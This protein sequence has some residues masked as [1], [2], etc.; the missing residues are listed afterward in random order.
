LKRKINK[1]VFL[2][3]IISLFSTN[4][5]YPADTERLISSCDNNK[6]SDCRKLAVAYIKQDDLLDSVDNIETILHLYHKACDAKDEKACLHLRTLYY[7]DY[8]INLTEKDANKIFR[9]LEKSILLGRVFNNLGCLYARGSLIVT[10]NYNK[11]VELFTLVCKNNFGIGCYNLGVMYEQ[12]Q[13]VNKDYNK[14][15]ELYIKGC[16][17][18]HKESCLSVPDSVV[19]PK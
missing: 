12:G 3:F 16:K 15:L 9:K 6:V 8:D 19:L 1:I 17:L 7:N 10:V 2:L 11:A 5:L 4:N 13:A 18:G 14:A